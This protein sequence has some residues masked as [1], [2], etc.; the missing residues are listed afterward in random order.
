MRKYAIAL[1]LVAAFVSGQASAATIK[2][3][4]ADATW[5]NVVTDSGRSSVTGVDTSQL[6]WGTPVAGR[7]SGYGFVGQSSTSS[8]LEQEFQLGIFTHYNN[9]IRTGTSIKEATLSLSVDLTIDGE[10]MTVASAFRFLHDETSNLK[11]GQVCAD[12]GMRGTGVN[13]NGCA[14]QVT[15]ESVLEMLDEFRIGDAIYTMQ[16]RGFLVGGETVSE[17][18]TK[19]RA[20]NSATLIA[21]FSKL[22]DVVPPPPVPVPLPAA[23]L[24]LLAGFGGL[25]AVK[26][27][28]GQ[29]SA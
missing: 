27:L 8:D 7:K 9:P 17:F 11:R 19:E 28:R 13:V 3:D 4:V 18:W 20:T 23:G 12:G 5:D 16:I 15:F 26:R 10:K 1:A 29:R 21:K 22:R 25:A 2:V 6:R 24:M 14:D